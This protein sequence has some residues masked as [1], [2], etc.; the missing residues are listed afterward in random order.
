[1]LYDTAEGLNVPGNGLSCPCSTGV[2]T[3]DY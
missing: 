1:M 2:S 3:C